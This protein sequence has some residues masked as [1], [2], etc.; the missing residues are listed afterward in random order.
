MNTKNHDH[1]MHTAF[2]TC[3]QINN[4]PLS[5]YGCNKT[6]EGTMVHKGNE[7]G[8]STGVIGKSPILYMSINRIWVEKMYYDFNKT[9]NIAGML[10]C[11]ST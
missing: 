10:Y 2:C 9:I 7:P 8:K 4:L 3:L 11:R 6:V 5:D 1:V